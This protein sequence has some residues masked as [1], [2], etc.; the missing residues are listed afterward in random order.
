MNHS[1]LR[2]AL[3]VMEQL[4][5]TSRQMLSFVKPLDDRQNI[6]LSAA[7]TCGLPGCRGDRF[8]PPRFDGC[9]DRPGVEQQG[10]VVVTHRCQQCVSRVP[11]PMAQWV[12]M[13]TTSEV[14]RSP[15]LGAVGSTC[16]ATKSSRSVG[17]EDIR[18][19]P[20]LWASAA[21]ELVPAC[22]GMGTPG[23]RWDEQRSG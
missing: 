10:V 22:R 16:V 12:Y 3:L 8:L 21:R 6:E 14:S 18:T 13:P 7:E 9:D 20:A 5:Q 15:A 2:N 17:Q 1:R 11:R 23:L 19:R 4:W